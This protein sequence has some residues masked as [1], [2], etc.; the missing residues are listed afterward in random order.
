MDRKSTYLK[1]LGSKGESRV[2]FKLRT[3]L[4][5]LLGDKERCG[6]CKGCNGNMCGR[7]C[8]VESLLVIEEDYWV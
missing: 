6:M 1:E 4:A 5:G 7:C 8:T 3:V 2:R